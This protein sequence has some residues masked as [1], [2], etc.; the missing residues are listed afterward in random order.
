[1]NITPETAERK[2][3]RL[4]ITDAELVRRLGVPEKR[5]R[6]ILPELEKKYNFPKKSPIFGDLRYWPA[7]KLWFDTHE[8]IITGGDK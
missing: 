5:L 2:K 8:G 1:M 6:L 7:V 3:T 4:Y